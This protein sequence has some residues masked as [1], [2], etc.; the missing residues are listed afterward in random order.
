MVKVTLRLQRVFHDRLMRNY[1]DL[2]SQGEW[3]MP[4][5]RERRAEGSLR[6]RKV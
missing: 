3:E 2:T 6:G 5:K 4:E 1:S